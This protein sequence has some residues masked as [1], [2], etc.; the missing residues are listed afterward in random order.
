MNVVR[1]INQELTICGQITPEQ[2]QTLADDGYKSILN[3]R[4]ADE[5]NS[6]NN[7][8]EKTELLGLCYVN[9]PIKIENFH[10]QYAIEVFH[11]ISELPKP[12]L[13]HCDNSKRSVVIVLLYI[14]TKQGIDFE[15]AWQQAINLDLL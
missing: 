6:W 15:Q 7:E 8:Q 9:F 1:K 10:H 2:L 3:L 14:S 13:I 11:V 4:F 12:L 5:Q